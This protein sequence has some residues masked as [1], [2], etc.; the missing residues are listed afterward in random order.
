MWKYAVRLS[1]I[2]VLALASCAPTGA[3]EPAVFK[4]V[5]VDNF[6]ITLLVP[7]GWQENYEEPHRYDG[8]DGYVRFYA[9]GSL[10]MTLEQSVA[11]LTGSIRDRYPYGTEPTVEATTAAEQPARL[12]LSSADYH[13]MM[14]RDPAA[15]V[16]AYPE[17]VT[18]GNG[19]TYMHLV[20]Q[21]DRNH[22]RDLGESLRFVEA[23]L[24][25]AGW[26]TSTPWVSPTAPAAGASASHT[27]APYPKPWWTATPGVGL[28]DS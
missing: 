19:M 4:R 5:N 6:H 17:P 26:P 12:I 22:V 16:V 28:N 24:A 2:P 21:A 15:L 13:Q 10:G 23:S 11:V 3:Q 1:L 27:P 25:P 18:L 14:P 7:E 20:L 9:T 8:D